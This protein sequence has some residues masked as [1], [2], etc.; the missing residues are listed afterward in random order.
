M[1]EDELIDK[2]LNALRSGPLPFSSIYTKH[3]EVKNSEA[4]TRMTM[5]MNRMITHG[6]IK[7]LL[8]EYS[9]ELVELNV[10][11]GDVLNAGGWI[12]YKKQNV[13]NIKAKEQ[14]ER[15]KVWIPIIL[16]IVGLFL[17]GMQ[18][19]QGYRQD[20]QRH[21]IETIQRER[22]SLYKVTNDHQNLLKTME[23]NSSQMR[24]S[25][26]SLLFTLRDKN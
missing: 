15:N 18:I 19:Y 6:L 22:D 14:T 24:K 4:N 17:V 2:V 26:D 12:A 11:G 23:Q 25:V 7:K 3:V 13:A 8:E 5:L 21:K 10:F 1:S 9:Y 16:T 20:E